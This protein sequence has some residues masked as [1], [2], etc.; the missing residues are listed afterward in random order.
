MGFSHS[1][2]F[3]TSQTYGGQRREETSVGTIIKDAQMYLLLKCL[4]LQLFFTMCNV[5]KII[6]SG[7]KEKIKNAMGTVTPVYIYIWAII[8]LFMTQVYNISCLIGFHCFKMRLQMPASLTPLSL[9]F[10]LA[11]SAQICGRRN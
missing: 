8:K 10:L 7:C 5:V 4:Y 1:S 6:K 3:Y 9:C 2:N 11:S